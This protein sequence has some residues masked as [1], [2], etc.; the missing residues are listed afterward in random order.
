MVC[1]RGHLECSPPEVQRVADLAAQLGGSV[2]KLFFLPLQEVLATLGILVVIAL[3]P[4]PAVALLV[5]PAWSSAAL[6]LLETCLL[7][8]LLLVVEEAA[9]DG[10]A[11]RNATRTHRLVDTPCHLEHPPA[12]ARLNDQVEDL[13]VGKEDTL[14]LEL[15]DDLE[16][17]IGPEELLFLLLLPERAAPHIDPA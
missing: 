4:A 17:L 3:L 15:A 16:Q 10:V 9:E 11:G 2:K 14:G 6:E 7:L 8:L 5:T 12:H 1:A 13:S